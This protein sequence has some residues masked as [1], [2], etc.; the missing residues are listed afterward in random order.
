M[1]LNQKQS[2]FV[3]FKNGSGF[4]IEKILKNGE[5]IDSIFA[6]DLS[7]KDGKISIKNLKK[8]KYELI[9]NNKKHYKFEISENPKSI[10]INPNWKVKF[11]SAVEKTF[12]IEMKELKSWTEFD[13]EK[14]KYFSGSATYSCHFNFDEELSEKSRWIL[15]LGKVEQ[16]A[17]VTLNGK[18]LPTLW[19][20][21][22]EVDISSCL[23]RGENILSIR[24]TNTWQNRLIGDENYPPIFDFAAGANA[25]L[26]QKNEKGQTIGHACHMDMPDGVYTPL[27]GVT[28][29][30]LKSLYKYYEKSDELQASGLLG[31]VKIREEK[32]FD[33]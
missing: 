13:D 33:F 26:I 30:K 31:D 19:T 16:F 2:G 8:G 7:L 29:R 24:V 15:D 25:F 27:K 22:F 12:E 20:P 5:F 6:T 10:A 23:K 28:K 32:I 9:A 4:H 17:E 11:E 3:Y 18:K 14:L 21:P 1:S